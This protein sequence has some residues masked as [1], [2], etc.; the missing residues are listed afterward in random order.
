MVI[1]I[2]Q[3][4]KDFI[5]EGCESFKEASEL[6]EEKCE[7]H[8]TKKIQKIEE[9]NYFFALSKYQKFL[10]NHIKN[11]QNLSGQNQEGTKFYHL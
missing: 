3:S 7:F 1:F 8:P 10:L 4:I 2:K 9:Q 5:C 6:N 11:T